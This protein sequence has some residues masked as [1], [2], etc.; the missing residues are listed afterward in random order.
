M[1]LNSRSMHFIAITNAQQLSVARY[2]KECKY[3]RLPT[4]KYFLKRHFIMEVHMSAFKDVRYLYASCKS[5]SILHWSSLVQKI[6]KRAQFSY[7]CIFNEWELGF[8]LLFQISQST[9]SPFPN[10][11]FIAL[12]LN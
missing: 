1:Q 4:R 3:N 8:F 9:I 7:T 10:H 6:R 12:Y 5:T 2:N 11:F